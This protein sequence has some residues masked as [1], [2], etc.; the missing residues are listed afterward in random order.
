MAQGQ[1]IVG[2]EKGIFICSNCSVSMKSDISTVFLYHL[3]KTRQVGS[4]E[5]ALAGS[6]LF[7]SVN[8][9]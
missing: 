7:T 2:W 5:L 4:G 9:L 6:A 8:V 3:Q 1:P